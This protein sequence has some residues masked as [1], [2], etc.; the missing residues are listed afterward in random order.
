MTTHINSALCLF[1]QHLT[2]SLNDIFRFSNHRYIFTT[3]ELIPNNIRHIY[4]VQSIDVYD[5]ITVWYDITRSS[6]H[7]TWWHH[8]KLQTSDIIHVSLYASNMTSRDYLDICHETYDNLLTW[9]L[10]ILLHPSPTPCHARCPMSIYCVQCTHTHRFC[11]I[12]RLRPLANGNECHYLIVI[13]GRMS[14]R[15]TMSSCIPM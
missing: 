11:F 6:V 8:I 1:I 15:P 14:V 13:S 5:W 10:M 3:L 12:Y 2:L 4:M 9:N 7:L